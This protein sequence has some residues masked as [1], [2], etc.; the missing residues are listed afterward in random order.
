MS[1][2]DQN[3]FEELSE[4]IPLLDAELAAAGRDLSL[5]VSAHSDLAAGLSGIVPMNLLD[6]RERVAIERTEYLA[7]ESRLDRARE[8]FFAALSEFAELKLKIAS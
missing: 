6:A 8:K 7:V 2:T 1:T 5:Y 4:R 3:R